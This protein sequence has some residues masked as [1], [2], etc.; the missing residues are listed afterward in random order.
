MEEDVAVCLGRVRGRES[1]G[2]H[3]TTKYGKGTVLSGV[4]HLSYLVISWQYGIAVADR[5]DP[6]KLSFRPEVSI[7][8]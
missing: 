4:S 3:S 5:A 7:E 6:S 2:K 8:I 1:H